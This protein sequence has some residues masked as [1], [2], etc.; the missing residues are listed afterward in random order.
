[1][2]KV[3]I[4]IIMGVKLKPFQMGFC[5]KA[6]QL[7]KL[8]SNWFQ[9]LPLNLIEQFLRQIPIFGGKTFPRDSSFAVKF[10]EALRGPYHFA[11]NIGPASLLDA[12]NIACLKIIIL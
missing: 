1:M 11:H 8:F 7:L 9:S 12:L 10:S 4:I 6:K 5:C 2:A 3:Y